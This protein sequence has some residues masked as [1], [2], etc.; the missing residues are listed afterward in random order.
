MMATPTMSENAYLVSIKTEQVACPTCESNPGFPCTTPRMVK[1]MGPHIKRVHKA[2]RALR[3][4]GVACE[5][6]PVRIPKPQPYMRRPPG[7]TGRFMKVHKPKCDACRQG[8][9]EPLL[10]TRNGPEWRYLCSG[11]S[12]LWSVSL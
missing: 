10:R 8:S 5:L 7:H 3:K 6:P 1:L 9:T 11:C 12:V 4:A 2:M